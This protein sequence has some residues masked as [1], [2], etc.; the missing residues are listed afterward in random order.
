MKTWQQL[1]LAPVASIREA[2]ACIDSGN[3]QVALVANEHGVLL[4]TV[5]DGDV[6]RGLLRGLSLD[7]P[8]SKVMNK[9]PTTGKPSEDRTALLGLM[10]R[11]LLH[12]IPL[13]DKHGQRAF[14]AE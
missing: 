9:T 14:S 5:T 6:R 2:I 7:D 13:V 8:V 12:Q 4:G 3:A 11:R 1:L 10:K